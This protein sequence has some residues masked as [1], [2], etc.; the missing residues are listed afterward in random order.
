LP[1]SSRASSSAATLDERAVDRRRLQA[2]KTWLRLALCF[3]LAS[4]IAEGT[5]ST[6]T[7]TQPRITVVYNNVPHAPGL[8]TAWGFA[9]LVESGGHTVLFDT[10]GDGPTLLANLAQ[11]NVEP[12]PVEAIV[13]S[14]IHGDHTGGL[15]DFLARHSRLTVYLPRSF[16]AAFRDAVERRGARVE[17]VGGA[18][19]LFASFHS[20]GELGDGT[21]EQALIVETAAGLVVITGCA[22]PDIVEIARAAR[23]T[24]GK[25]IHLLMGG[26][27][28]LGRGADRNRATIAALRRLGVRKVAPSHCTGDEAIALF[29]EAWKDDFIDGGVGAV[30]ELP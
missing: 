5:M 19:H 13:L 12:A 11:L 8:A 27:H 17:T 28:L 30:I 24:L 2:M 1:T 23:A 6:E 22:H 21:K 16:P 18:R 29:R 14:H 26:F 10:G 3:L 25:D 9:A 20:T 15:D 7:G 4:M